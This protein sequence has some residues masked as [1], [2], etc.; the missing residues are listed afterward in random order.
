M[1]YEFNPF[2]GQF[3]LI[4]D[5]LTGPLVISGSNERISGNTYSEYIDFKTLGDGYIGF[6]GSGGLNN[7]SL[8]MLL[9]SSVG[10]VLSSP[11]SSAINL[12]ENIFIGSAATSPAARLHLDSGNATAVYE[13]FTA[14]TTTGQ[15]STDGFDIG[16]DS[17]GNAE[18]R[19]RENLPLTF[20]TNN[21]SV[22]RFQ[23]IGRFT[24]GDVTEGSPFFTNYAQK[25]LVNTR[26]TTY[27]TDSSTFTDL[28]QLM[29]VSSVDIDPSANTGSGLGA[30]IYAAQGYTTDVEG[31]K[32]FTGLAV[33]GSQ[34]SGEP[35]SAFGAFGQVNINT[36]GGTL[37]GAVGLLCTV[38]H[39]GLGGNANFI[40]AS[41]FN[42]NTDGSIDSTPTGTVTTIIGGRFTVTLGGVSATNAISGRFVEPDTYDP[43]FAPE[44]SQ[45]TNK[46]AIDLR[47]TLSILD[48]DVATAASITN[49]A[50]ETSVIRMTGSTATNLHGIHADTF[51]KLIWIYNVS[52]ATV[53]LKHQ[54]ATE[55][56]AANRIICNT[57]ADV[58]ITTGKSACLWYDDNQSRWI[59]L[60]NS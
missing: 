43:G 10:P 3:D 14:G 18:I 31:N 47:G 7:V 24:V 11:S 44:P 29:C 55:G 5:S 51:N 53:T 6:Y 52:S 45:P 36:T 16:I 59:H 26:N 25:M 40:L 50:V 34:I 60:F 2:T 9:D 12:I 48:S 17:S 20:Y 49:M 19:Q 33:A 57:G 1:R 37:D 46:T 54:S 39:S 27:A 15:T 13:K 21:S 28:L 32:T 22:A 8:A 30:T 38:N 23:A 4:G 41:D 42:A 58:A 56:T 35:L